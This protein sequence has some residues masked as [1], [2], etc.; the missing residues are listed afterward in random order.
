MNTMIP[1]HK[2][3]FTE[4]P[5]LIVKNSQFSV[6]AF[7]YHSGVQG[8]RVENQ[9]GHLTILPFLGQMI[10]DAEFCGQNLKMEN[11]FS[12]PKPVPHRD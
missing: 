11:M 10:W 6:S 2:S 8:L 7:V 1:L 12:E 3:L 4:K 5:T 9:Q